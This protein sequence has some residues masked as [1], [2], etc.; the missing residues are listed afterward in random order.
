VHRQTPRS[1][2]VKGAVDMLEIVLPALIRASG[3]T[4]RH[5]PEHSMP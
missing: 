5:P 2:K 4:G 3:A 1:A